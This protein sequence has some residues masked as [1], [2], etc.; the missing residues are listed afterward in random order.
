MQESSLKISP[1]IVSKAPNITNKINE[2][3]IIASAS[4][5]SPFPLAMELKGHLP[6]QKDW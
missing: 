2:L 6:C 5:L 3:P 4:S 1:R